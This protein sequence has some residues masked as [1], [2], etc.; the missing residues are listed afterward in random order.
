MRLGVVGLLL[1]GLATWSGVALA[2][3]QLKSGPRQSEPAAPITKAPAPSLYPMPAPAAQPEPCPPPP[4]HGSDEPVTGTPKV[5]TANLPPPAA[6]TPRQV[7][8][9]PLRGKGMWWTTW[10]TSQ[11]DVNLMVSQ[12][13]AA[14][15]TQIWVRTGSSRQGWYG[16][17][18]LDAL[19]PAAHTAGIA[20]V[21]WDFP[22]LSDP[23]A[24][25]TRARQA[26]DETFG[27]QRIDA[28]S[29]DIETAYEGTYDS[30]ARVALY[31]SLVRA[32]AS[33][34]PVVATVMNPTPRQLVNY[35]YAAQAP[36]VDAFAPMV[37]WSC[38][39]PG[40]AAATAIAA[41]AA[42][43]PV[44]LIGQAYDMADEGGRHGLPTGAEIW[45][46]LDVADRAGAIGASLYVADTASQPEWSALGGYPWKQGY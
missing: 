22:T 41:L 18:L 4:V 15:L 9:A 5:A 28:F 44:H 30:P 40:Q 3:P 27:G 25:A 26:I 6:L 36:Y 10:P 21:A 23:V 12:A 37:Y 2:A 39:E 11:V 7:D 19:L 45:R 20:V 16:A 43:R 29:P 13:K 32:A 33:T 8:L 38:T 17:P 34:L 1:A 46:F 35:P 14:G 42:L 24:D 31:L